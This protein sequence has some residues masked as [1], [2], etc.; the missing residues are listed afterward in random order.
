MSPVHITLKAAVMVVC[1]IRVIQV[2][3]ITFTPWHS[4]FCLCGYNKCTFVTGICWNK[5][6]LLDLFSCCFWHVL[7]KL[8]FL[9]R[10]T[11]SS[12]PPKSTTSFSTSKRTTSSH[13]SAVTKGCTSWF[14][15]M[16]QVCF[17]LKASSVIIFR[18]TPCVNCVAHLKVSTCCYKLRKQL[19]TCWSNV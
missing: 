6:Y 19:N 15:K 16:N 14:I 7:C 13:A 4:I 12:N 17:L 11:S 2:A 18:C 1:C 9:H 5:R 3:T 8:L 10:R